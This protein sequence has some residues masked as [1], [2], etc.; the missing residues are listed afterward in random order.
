MK[1]ATLRRN[2]TES[3]LHSSARTP[4]LEM[5][6][7]LSSRFTRHQLCH[8][9][10]TVLPNLSRRTCSGHSKTQFYPHLFHRSKKAIRSLRHRRCGRIRFRRTVPPSRPPCCFLCPPTG[11][12]LFCFFG[13]HLRL[14]VEARFCLWLVVP[15]TGDAP[16][17]Y[18]TY[19]PKLTW[20]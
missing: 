6:L 10:P 15:S 18:S 3:D 12:C 14:G 9:W 19:P 5:E 11:S 20:L 13:C 7:L 16:S 17:G 4:F 1:V 2:T 8:N